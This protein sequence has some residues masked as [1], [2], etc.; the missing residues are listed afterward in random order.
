MPAWL[1]SWKQLILPDGGLGLL[2]CLAVVG[3]AVRHRVAGPGVGFRQDSSARFPLSVSPCGLA[4]RAV[5]LKG[6]LVRGCRGI[7]LLACLGPGPDLLDEL[8]P[9]SASVVFVRPLMAVSLVGDLP[10]G[11][12]R[13]ARRRGRLIVGG[14]GR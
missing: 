14:R 7:V 11:F 2:P 4:D 10:R 13:G 3:S 5:V 1:D 8:L 6:S 9:G 12:R